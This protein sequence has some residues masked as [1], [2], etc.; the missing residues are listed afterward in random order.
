MRY[1]IIRWVEIWKLLQR[2]TAVKRPSPAAA[3]HQEQPKI[4]LLIP[5]GS[6]NLL[7]HKTFKWLVEY[8]QHELPDAEIVVGRSQA[9]IFCKGRALNN[10]AKRA[11]GKVLVVLDADTYMPGQVIEKCAD[12]I[13]E[14]LPNHLWY[15]PYRRLYRLNK[16]CTSRVLASSPQKPYRFKSPP[17][18][19]CLDKKGKDKSGYG[20]RFGAM[21]TIL[22]RE[23]LDVLGCFDERFKG[24]GGEDVAILRALDTL[25]GLHKTTDN[26]VL[27]LHHPFIG[28]NY[29]TRKWG[30]QKQGGA[31]NKLASAY[32]VATGNPKAMRELV[33]AGCRK[34]KINGLF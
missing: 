30:G 6:S 1:I 27:H 13:L 24:W 2:R 32:N 21:I 5:F 25:Y 33:D 14:A 4:S 7:R 16:R 28:K 3:R 18:C 15:V 31:N 23:A 10:A 22:P 8:W 34:I 17:P 12:R 20:H 29:R 9:T 26:D 11:T 19:H